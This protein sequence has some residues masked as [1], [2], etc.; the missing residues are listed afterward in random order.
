MTANA[1][2]IGL[3]PLPVRR[4]FMS[5]V[6]DS[7]SVDIGRVRR[8]V[9][10]DGSYHAARRPARR[11]RSSCERRRASQRPLRLRHQ[12][13]AGP[14][15]CARR[16]GHALARHAA[17]AGRAIARREPR[18]A[19]RAGRRAPRR[20]S[21][22]RP[23]R[24]DSRTARMRAPRALR[25]Q[26]RRGGVDRVRRRSRSRRAPATP[27]AAARG[28]RSPCRIRMRCPAGAANAGSASR[29][30]ESNR[31]SGMAWTAMPCGLECARGGPA[32]WRRS[33]T[34]RATQLL[35]VTAPPRSRSC[36]SIQS[37][38]S[39]ASTLALGRIERHGLDVDRGK[40]DAGRAALGSR[41]R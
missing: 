13:R 36:R 26:A 39:G 18:A 5:V 27:R 40:R 9:R 37:C 14:L 22:R 29:P 11:A 19:G 34:C 4:V 31:P 2:S 20:S 35:R 8:S 23:A 6:R 16:S 24:R 10:A 21:P 38:A 25:A 7:I 12:D 15:P 32:D 28:R 1:T 3:I 17:A 30:S 41:A 33:G